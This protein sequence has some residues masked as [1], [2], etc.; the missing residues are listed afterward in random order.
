MRSTP[1]N[2]NP[3]DDAPTNDAADEAR[4]IE[5]QH[6]AHVFWY[7]GEELPHCPA[8]KTQ[9]TIGAFDTFRG[10][11]HVV[12]LKCDS[13]ACNATLLH[14]CL[15]CAWCSETYRERER[16]SAAQS[17]P[18][19]DEW[20]IELQHA[21]RVVAGPLTREAAEAFCQL[22]IAEERGAG[23][24]LSAS[25]AWLHHVAFKRMSRARAA[26]GLERMSHDDWNTLDDAVIR[27]HA[28]A[29]IEEQRAGRPT[30]RRTVHAAVSA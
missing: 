28:V 21:A 7:E 12:R 26:E 18:S 1:L 3:D 29:I 10:F 24:S 6:A 20:L 8:C 23:R 13:R 19:G 2:A 16:A 15:G 27:V 25:P 22:I 17:A 5:L 30:T 4:L 9:L 11:D 14:V